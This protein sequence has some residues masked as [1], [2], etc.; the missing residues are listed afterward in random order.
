MNTPQ[1]D[2][3]NDVDILRRTKLSFGEPANLYPSIVA[4]IHAQ[5]GE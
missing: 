4:R 1:V 5:E 2:R 3:Q